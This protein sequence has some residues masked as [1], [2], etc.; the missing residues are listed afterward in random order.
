MVLLPG[1]NVF[2][3]TCED[4]LLSGY[5]PEWPVLFRKLGEHLRHE[6]GDV[7]IRIDHIGSTAIPGIV[8]KPIIDVQISVVALDPIDSFRPNIERC[9]FLWRADNTDLTKRYFRERPGERRTHIH[10]RRHG[11]FS[12]Q[13]AL[14]FRDYMRCHPDRVREYADL[15]QRLLPLLE[16]DREAYT[17]AKSPFT[18]QTIQIADEWAKASGWKPGPTDV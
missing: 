2:S 7:A 4:I 10:V 9:G 1:Q 8:A 5:D 15:K 3:G 6:L 12:E 11:S 16:L 18:W 14:L 17:N 13:F